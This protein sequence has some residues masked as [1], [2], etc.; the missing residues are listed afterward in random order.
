M[1]VFYN[2]IILLLF[3]VPI[4]S[5]T[6]FSQNKTRKILNIPDIPGY[7]TLKCDLHMHTVFSDGNVWP[8]FR[9]EE[10]WAEGL[11]VIAITDHL[12]HNIHNN[13]DD[14]NFNRSYEIAKPVADK[15]GMVLIRGSE[16]TT[17]NKLWT[18]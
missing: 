11:D 10:A 2:R 1:N 4:F 18:Y 7:K 5:I 15:L 16:I 17:K 3:L 14:D 8:S 13:V 6:G 9:V 12:G